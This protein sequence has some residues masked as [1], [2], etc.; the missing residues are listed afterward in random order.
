M[1]GGTGVFALGKGHALYT[2]AE[3]MFKQI[4]VYNMPSRQEWEA[5]TTLTKFNRSVHQISTG[6]AQLVRRNFLIKNACV[7]SIMCQ[8]YAVILR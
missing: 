5:Q 7:L 8:L 2:F 4:F 6:S 3:S 1:P